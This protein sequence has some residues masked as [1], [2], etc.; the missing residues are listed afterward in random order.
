[1]EKEIQELLDLL[2]NDFAGY[3][4]FREDELSP[5]WIYLDVI[6][7]IE[8]YIKKKLKTKKE[9]NKYIDNEVK[10]IELRIGDRFHIAEDDD[11][12]LFN[13]QTY[14]ILKHYPDDYFNYEII[15][16]RAA[17]QS[18]DTLDQTKED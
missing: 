8:Y 9:I 7:R 6:N 16:F 14:L 3:L 2:R 4:P 13:A 17:V 15:G 1:M 11:L 5:R 18:N 10:A 12:T